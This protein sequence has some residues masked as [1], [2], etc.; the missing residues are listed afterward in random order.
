I[1]LAERLF[2]A[3]SEAVL[4]LAEWFPGDT[5]GDL[6]WRLALAGMDLL[7]ADLDF[8]LNTRLAVVHKARDTFA[9]EFQIDVPFKHQLAAKFRS[10]RRS[11]EALLEHNIDENAPIQH[12][13]EIL[14]QKRS[15]QL[16]GVMNELRLNAKNGRLSLPL[17]EL[18]PSYLHMH[19]NRL[20]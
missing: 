1:E 17:T 13:L 12:G 15:A 2:H 9:S 11:L 18:A 20:L 19:A 16:T 4:S 14:R 5:R 10:E 3:D 7:M 8:D 6:R